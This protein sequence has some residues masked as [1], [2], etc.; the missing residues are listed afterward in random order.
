MLKARSTQVS[1]SEDA[2]PL[3]DVLFSL[4][5]IRETLEIFSKSHQQVSRSTLGWLAGHVGDGCEILDD[6]DRHIDD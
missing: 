5:A 6:I 4:N 3:K 1:G 2:F